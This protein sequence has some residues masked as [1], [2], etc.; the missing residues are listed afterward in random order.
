MKGG[1]YVYAITMYLRL[2]FCLYC[3]QMCKYTTFER[4]SL[5]TSFNPAVGSSK[6]EFKCPHHKVNSQSLLLS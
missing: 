1:A 6:I 5:P 2:S 3:K 4:T